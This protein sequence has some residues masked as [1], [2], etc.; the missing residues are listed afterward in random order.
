MIM[1][2]ITQF[3][4]S[5]LLY[6]IFVPILQKK[7]GNHCFQHGIAFILQYFVPV[8]IMTPIFRVKL[9]CLMRLYLQ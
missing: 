3:I 5:F 4:L 1:K 2:Y 6:K 9:I 8:S 7:V